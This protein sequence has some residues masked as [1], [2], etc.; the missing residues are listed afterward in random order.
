M[1]NIGFLSSSIF[2]QKNINI[3]IFMTSFRIIYLAK[4]IT[5][6]LANCFFDYAITKGN[7]DLKSYKSNCFT[8][9]TS[10]RYTPDEF[11][12]III[13]LGAFKQSIAI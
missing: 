6:D 1:I 12:Q 9:I 3:D 13:D 10:K 11:Y 4:I 2:D 7:P 5:I 8:H